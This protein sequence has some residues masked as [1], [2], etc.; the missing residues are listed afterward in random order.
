LSTETAG[1]TMSSA[2][3]T[4]TGPGRPANAMLIAFSSSAHVSA[5]S[6]SSTECLVVA[7]IIASESGVRPIPEVSLSWPFPW[8]SSEE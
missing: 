8:N 1:W 5:G 4:C 6:V 3:A 2:T 7:R